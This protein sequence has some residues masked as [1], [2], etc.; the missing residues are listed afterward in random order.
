MTTHDEMIGLK[1][2][3]ELAQEIKRRA[4]EDDRTVSAFLRRLIAASLG[5]AH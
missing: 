1:V 4:R 5:L 3:R 2:P